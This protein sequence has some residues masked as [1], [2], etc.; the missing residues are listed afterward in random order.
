MLINDD[1]KSNLV[2][3]LKNFLKNPT[4]INDGV[5]EDY[6]VF[7]EKRIAAI[8]K[9]KDL[10]DSFLNRKLSL[11]EF[12]EKSEIECRKFPYWGFKNFSGQMQL[13]QYANNINDSQ[14]EK[15]LKEAMVLPK[16]ESEASIKI[17]SMASY[18]SKL[19]ERTDNPKSIP[20]VSQYY[21][22]S[23]FW[24]IQDYARWP[25]YYGSTRK[26]MLSLG[27]KLDGLESYGQEY[28]EFL[29]IM[30]EV[31]ILYDAAGRSSEK[32]PYWF[33][34]HVLWNQFIKLGSQAQDL[35]VQEG[36]KGKTKLVPVG[37]G[38]WIPDIVKDLNELS[39]NK[40]TD[41]SKKMDVKAE[42]AFE[43]KLRYVFTLLGYEAKELGQGTGRE[44]DGIALSI[45][46]H[47][48]DYAIVYDAKARENGFSIG[49]GDREIYEYIQKKREELRRHRINKTYFVIVS[50]EFNEAANIGPIR[51]I[52]R[53]T[54]VP[55][56]LLK[57]ID[58]LFIIDAKLQNV[59]IDHTRLEYLFLDTGLIS[60]EKIIDAL[61]MR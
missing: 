53:K 49:T 19:K 18:L 61:G 44:P 45:G 33:I 8:P 1:Q 60:R 39:L 38:E 46:V 41:W 48:G 29:K 2:M 56:V 54:Q 21:L 37:M 42:K 43:T 26:V 51:E 27:F 20:R 7:D 25:V 13:N 40:D 22:L 28:L 47:D 12:K 10:A 14:K 16:N 24:E 50:S 31:K 6:H 36:K 11:K 3:Y 58:L 59:E 55:V 17:N 4:V 34:E 23:Y 32:F 15:L 52:Y 57:A 35:P 9:L 5:E 30:K